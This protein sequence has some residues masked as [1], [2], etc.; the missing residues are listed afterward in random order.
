ME[1]KRDQEMGALR[2]ERGRKG[3]SMLWKKRQRE[4][5]ALKGS[6]P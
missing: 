5:T 3:A 6:Q 2:D 4:N 1:L